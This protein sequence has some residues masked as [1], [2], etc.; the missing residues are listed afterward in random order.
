MRKPGT[1]ATQS[2]RT[3]LGAAGGGAMLS[4]AA[5]ALLAGRPALAA[6][7]QGRSEDIAILNVALG[8]EH[9]AI[10]AYQ[11][12][13]ESGLLSK[14][15]LDVAV[16][17]QSQ[18]KTHRDAL[19]STIEK[20]GGKPVAALPPSEYVK[21]E[22]LRVSEIKA[23]ADVLKLAQRLELGAANAYLG[24]IPVF[25]DRELAKIAGRLAADETMHY[26]ALTQAL[27]ESIPTRALS[28]GA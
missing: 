19:A 16:M 14:A 27:G 20:L 2:R 1:A 11:I 5:I 17:F 3:F 28:F 18:H 6:K 13:A 4:A 21:S 7:S 22:K 12:G 9:E 10:A 23:A 25:G 8:L 26:T 24:V 15:A